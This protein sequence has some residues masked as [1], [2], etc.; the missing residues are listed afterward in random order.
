MPALIQRITVVG[1]GLMG[2]GIAQEFAHGN[3][4]V[5]LVDI[6]AQKLEQ[7]RIHIEKN[8][9]MLVTFGQIPVA[10]VSS[11]LNNISLTTNLRQAV[12]D[13]DLVVEA[14]SEELNTKEGVFREL[15]AACPKDTI[16][17]TTSSA[18][19]PSK[20]AKVTR[21]PGNVIG[22]HFLNP[23]YLIHLVEVA[24]TERT[25]KAVRDAAI[26][27]LVTLGKKPVV[28]RREIPGLLINRLQTA[29]IR[30]AISLV[31]KGV[32]SAEEL[33]NA[34]V[35]ALGRRWAVAGVFELFDL[36]GWDTALAAASYILPDLESSIDPSPLREMVDPAS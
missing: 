12:A 6:S 35:Q 3:Y 31:A 8:L 5:S 34:V 33:D 20:L 22:M 11:V 32:V 26:E 24:L 9:Q 13:V 14:V 28:L 17:A 25:P 10:S 19:V 23:P 15:D 7:A 30:E 16:L 2:H 18:I 1:A 21:R 4:R 27:V 29:L 36:A